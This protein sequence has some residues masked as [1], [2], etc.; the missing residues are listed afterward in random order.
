MR[1]DWPILMDEV[2]SLERCDHDVNGVLSGGR[3]SKKRKGTYSCT[4]TG[5]LPR[6]GAGRSRCYLRT[7]EGLGDP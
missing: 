2:S 6:E 3:V 4:E 7:E 1:G 5:H